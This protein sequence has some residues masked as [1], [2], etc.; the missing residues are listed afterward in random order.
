MSVRELA[1]EAVSEQMFELMSKLASYLMIGIMINRN[2]VR[3]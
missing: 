3:I 1:Y 2:K